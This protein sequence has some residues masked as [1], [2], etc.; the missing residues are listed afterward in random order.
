MNRASTDH[1]LFEQSSDRNRRLLREEELILE[2][3]E[4]VSAAMEKEHISKPSLQSAWENQRLHFPA[5]V[6]QTESDPADALRPC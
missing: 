1:E 3:T 5:L 2:V 4:A 6:R